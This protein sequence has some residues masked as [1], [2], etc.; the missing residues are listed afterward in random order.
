MEKCSPIYHYLSHTHPNPSNTSNYITD[1][2][3][4]TSNP[5]RIS[6]E[7]NIFLLS[8]LIIF[9]IVLYGSNLCPITS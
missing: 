4:L 3:S 7:D 6:V 9:S 8:L 5:L 1:N 2:A